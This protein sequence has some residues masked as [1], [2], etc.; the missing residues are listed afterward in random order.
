MNPSILIIIGSL[1]LAACAQTPKHAGPESE[2]ALDPHAEA[3]L[4]LPN[5]ELSDELLYKF[6]L[7]EIASQRGHKAL[8]VEGSMDIAKKTRDPRMARRAAHLAFESGDMEK[9]IEAFRQWQEIEPASPLAARMLASILLRGGRLDEAQIELAKLLEA[10][11]ANPAA[12]FM[13][14]F[15]LVSSC[16]DKRDALRLMRNLAQPYAQIAEAHWSVAQLAR[17]VGDNQLALSEVR[18]ARSLLPAWDMAASLEAQLLQ[19]NAPQQ[20]LDVLREHL[21]DYPDARE[22]RLQYARVLLEQKQYRSA[23]AEFQRLAKDNP[24]NPEM[25]FAIALI[26]LQMNE[27]RDAETQ[28][29]QALEKSQKNRD[30][31]Q[32]YLGQ[33][34]EAKENEEGAIAHYREVKDGEYQFAAR[35]RVA[36]LL[37]KRGKLDEAVEYLRQA[38]AVD[39]QQRAQQTMIEAQLLYEAKRLDEAYQVL[40][41]GLAKLPNHP[42]LLYETAMLADKAG[43][44]DVFEQLMRKL[45]QIK[46]DHAH[47]YNA[48]GYRLLELEER[49]PEAVELVEKALQL[50]PDDAA[51]L[52][53]VGWGYYRSGKLDESVKLL[54]RA[55][56]GNPDP[57][58][59]AHLGEALWLHGDREEARK[60]WQDSLKANPGNAL[61]QAVIKKFIP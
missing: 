21:S 40:Q 41:Q 3:E 45:I 47:A 38:Q 30:T 14:V 44:L 11:K 28:L 39:N 22:I 17:Q 31:V 13:Q 25:A 7:S 37:N 26:S 48:L 24:E 46:P 56:A 52:D 51:I 57:E 12:G 32:Y 9:S 18:Q 54:R 8:A 58:V 53:S 59:A 15:Q 49:I 42:D 10:E 33:L 34:N 2:S 27:L 50:A 16:P 1:L 5:V 61:L 35:L 23:R 55:Y 20:A 43:K 4:V 36:Y 6:L 60:T 29:Q 19:K